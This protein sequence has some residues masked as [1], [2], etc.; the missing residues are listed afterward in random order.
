MNRIVVAILATLATLLTGVG[1]AAPTAAAP[2]P[3]A[4]TAAQTAAETAV[5]TP[6]PGSDC[7]CTAAVGAYVAPK[8]I[9]NP[10]IGPAGQSAATGA[11]YQVI[12]QG[13]QPNLTVAVK[14][15]S[16]AKVVLTITSAVGQWG[17]SP[18]QRTFVNHG[19]VNDST[20]TYRIEAFDLQAASPAADPLFSRVSERE[21]RRV[22]FS[23]HGRYFVFSHL[24]AFEQD[25][26][27]HEFVDTTTG[28]DFDIDYYFYI[29]PTGNGTPFGEAGFGFSPDVA[30]RGFSLSYVAGPV[31]VTEDVYDLGTGERT[32]THQRQGAGFVRF[33][34]CGDM[35]GLVD[36]INQSSL[37]IMAV[38]SNGDV[39]LN[40]VE[41]GLPYV[42][43]STSV[44]S[45]L[46]TIQTAPPVAFAPNTSRAVCPDVTAPR[47]SAGT[48]L[49]INNV[50]ATEMALGWLGASDNVKVTQYRI[51]RGDTVIATVPA[52]PYRATG[53]VPGTTYTFSVQAGDAAGNWSATRISASATTTAVAPTWPAGSAVTGGTATASSI[54]IT[55]TAAAHAAGVTAYR[56]YRDGV[57]VGTTSGNTRAY[58]AEG[59]DPGKAYTFKVEASDNA[60]HWT[61]TGPSARLRTVSLH[62][63]GTNTIS[64][65]LWWDVNGNGVKDAAE[66]RAPNDVGL[67]AYRLVDGN[68]ASVGMSPTTHGADGSYTYADLPDGTYVLSTL[69]Y[70]FVQTFPA[71]YQPQVVTI[72]DGQGWAGVDFGVDEGQFPELDE[73]PGAISG[74]VTGDGPLVGH[75]V[76]C[77]YIQIGS[78]C[79]NL[80]EDGI[81]TDGAGGFSV[82]GLQPGTYVIQPESGAGLA[83]TAPVDEEG[84]ALARV[85]VIG[86]DGDVV[87]GL[88]FTMGVAPDGPTEEPTPEVPTDEVPEPTPTP[89]PT[90]EPTPTPTPE[91]SPTPTTDPE[92]TPGP[93]VRPATAPRQ[94]RVKR[95]GR[96]AV[97]TWR[98]PAA[99][100]GSPI[101]D[102]VIQ[103]SVGTGRWVT[104]KDRVSATRRLTVRLPK[105]GRTLRFR[106]AATTAAG[107]GGWTTPVRLR[108]PARHPARH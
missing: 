25:H 72:A 57:L 15:L 90:P 37:R 8:A 1:L 101:V 54:P 2:S 28:R 3:T 69:D 56:V 34:P 85:V 59:L 9:V 11:K 99:T 100:G 65:V 79:T 70:P 108:L 87:S 24:Y 80:V 75:R 10:Y 36:Q 53:L 105:S 17:F 104:V 46:V 61:T 40:Q 58:A 5:T 107:V 20:T 67:Y 103:Q 30:D 93:V 42:A 74:T 27:H 63:V 91:P 71:D 84:S 6:T 13:E 96:V 106:V 23:P 31:D 22:G 102:F 51:Y 21:Q 95:T 78:G 52:A 33:S 39:V 62:Q 68:A 73:G 32:F 83:Q 92:P 98:A 26:V 14:R 41:P 50:Y 81:R 35:F 60:G 55:W 19:Y 43:F 16:D 49:K 18:D 64:G 97:L 44:A 7:G 66:G 47:W 29:P 82:T 45:H 38:A 48:E 4:R 77:Y 88:D 86:P 12:V 76:S 89:T 94:L